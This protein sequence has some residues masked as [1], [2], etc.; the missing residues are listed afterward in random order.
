ME[1]KAE[2]YDHR[3]EVNVKCMKIHK[4]NMVLITAIETK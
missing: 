4:G 3:A 1:D 2:E